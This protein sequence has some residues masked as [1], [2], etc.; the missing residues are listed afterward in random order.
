MYWSLYSSKR[1]NFQGSSDFFYISVTIQN[2]QE[3]SHDL[4]RYQ[5]FSIVSE[6][7]R[8]TLLPPPFNIL[9]YIFMLGRLLFLRLQVYRNSRRFSMWITN[10]FTLCTSCSLV[11]SER[12][13]VDIKTVTPVISKS[14]KGE[15]NQLDWKYDG[16]NVFSKRLASTWAC[17]CQRSLASCIQIG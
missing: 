10:N 6:Y 14:F 11:S 3:Q 1:E 7:C 17:N 8:K 12:L 2:V 5:R 9:Y 4:W 16:W 15:L 13:L